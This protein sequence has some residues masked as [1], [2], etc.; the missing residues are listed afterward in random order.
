MISCKTV[1]P[2]IYVS[3]SKRSSPHTYED[4]LLRNPARGELADLSEG[5][6]KNEAIDL[7]PS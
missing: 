4:D 6:E 3:A 2:R 7:Q 1:E 5:D